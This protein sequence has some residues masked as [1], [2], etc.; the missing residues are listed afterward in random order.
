MLPPNVTASLDRLASLGILDYDAAAHIAGT[1]PR[2]IGSPTCYVP[3]TVM[4]PMDYATFS[5]NP[6][7]SYFNN[8]GQYSGCN[9]PWK[10]IF[11]GVGILGGIYLLGKLFLAGLTGIQN[12]SLKNIFKSG[13]KVIQETIEDAD[14][15]AR[16]GGKRTRKFFRKT[17]TKLGIRKPWY[18]RA[19][20]KI[21]NG[22][23]SLTK[24][25]SKIKIR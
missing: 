2:Y 13:K 10:T 15:A 1:A 8:Y 19:G 16:R 4:T 12:F 7:C 17:A 20:K 24:S 6:G 9:M 5:Y 25:I 3:P 21:S 23:D 18:K 22:W 14:I 11:S